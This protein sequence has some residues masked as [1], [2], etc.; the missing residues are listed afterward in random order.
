MI[1]GSPAASLTFGSSLTHEWKIFLNIYKR[2]RW[3]QNSQ[4]DVE[5]ETKTSK[6]RK[7]KVKQKKEKNEIFLSSRKIIYNVELMPIRQ[8]E[9]HSSG[10][11]T[12]IYRVND[13]PRFGSKKR[14]SRGKQSETISC[15]NFSSNLHSWC[16]TGERDEAER[17]ESRK[18]CSPTRP[19]LYFRLL[20]VLV[21]SPS[22]S[23]IAH[24]G[25]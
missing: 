11:F 9:I 18:P 14:L 8:S 3:E 2:S 25:L 6:K 20:S 7:K 1:G 23:S 4:N 21:V 16:E 22:S 19:Q 10:S 24:D 12:N 15:A 5:T 17:I 13:W